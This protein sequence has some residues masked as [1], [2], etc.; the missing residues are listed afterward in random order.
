MNPQNELLLSLNFKSFI[1]QISLD[2]NFYLKTKT[3]TKAKKN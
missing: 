1:L 3:L 2:L